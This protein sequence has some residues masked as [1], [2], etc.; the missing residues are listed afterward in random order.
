MEIK[1]QDFITGSGKRVLTDNGRQGVGGAAG[2][3]STTEKQQGNVAEAIFSNCA[4]LNNTQLDDIIR[5]VQ[6]Y[7]S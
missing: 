2:I 7:K 1:A 5:W 6:L 4:D 3:G